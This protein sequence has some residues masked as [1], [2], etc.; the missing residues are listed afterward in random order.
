MLGNLKIKAVF[1]H[2]LGC[3]PQNSQGISLA[4]LSTKALNQRVILHLCLF[5][6]PLSSSK[7][8]VQNEQIFNV[9]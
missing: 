4:N 3:S 1:N 7:L 8:K 9:R 5:T 2:H 6:C